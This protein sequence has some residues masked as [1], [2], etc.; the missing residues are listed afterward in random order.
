MKSEATERTSGLKPGRDPALEAPHIGLGRSNIMFAREQQCDVDRN[1][2]ENGLFD[3]RRAL[4]GAGNLDEQIGPGRSGMKRTRGLDG[5][6]GVIGEERRY[7]ERDPAID[8]GR[9]VVD[10]P[11]QI[12]CLLQIGD[13]KSEEQ[14]FVRN[15]ALGH[16]ADV[17]IVRGAL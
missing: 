13:R 10:R 6:L 3:R 9:A 4:L 1:A 2:P 12:R 7:F 8:A 15:A 11:E 16:R 17:L 5:T 14:I